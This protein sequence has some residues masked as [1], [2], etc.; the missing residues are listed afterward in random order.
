MMLWYQVVL[1]GFDSGEPESF[2]CR[3]YAQRL[4]NL[5]DKTQA[6]TLL[7]LTIKEQI[8]FFIN[9]LVKCCVW[10]SNMAHP[11]PELADSQNK[12]ED[13]SGISSSA[14]S[15]PYDALIEACENNPVGK[16]FPRIH[17]KVPYCNVLYLYCQES[18]MVVLPHWSMLILPGSTPSS[19]L[20]PSQHSKCSAEGQTTLPR[21]LRADSGPYSPEI[22]GPFNW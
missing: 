1:R 7:D 4:S 8:S 2:W 6:T 5:I 15:N 20:N 19:L 18:H 12:F 22:G 11:L 21:V 13:L 9:T 17:L 10:L 16:S 14:Y 3:L